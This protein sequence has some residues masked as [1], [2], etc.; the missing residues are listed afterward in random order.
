MKTLFKVPQRVHNA[1]MLMVDLAENGRPGSFV[2][3]TEVA[4]RK[5]L[6]RGFLEEIAAPLKTAGLIGAKRG[7]YGGYCLTREPDEISVGD[8]V[9]AIEGPLALVDCLGGSSCAI[10][11]SCTSK[12]VWS[13]VQRHVEDSLASISL[14]DVMNGA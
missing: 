11:G 14:A 6:S 1:V 8:V 2:S 5:A 13:T 3:L 10:A 12:N 7:A 4:D 9:M